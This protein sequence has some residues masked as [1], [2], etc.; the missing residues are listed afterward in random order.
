MKIYE[1][2]LI[3]AEILSIIFAGIW[4]IYKLNSMNIDDLLVN[5]TTYLL[6]IYVAVG[7]LINQFQKSADIKK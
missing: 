3:F 6:M 7:N 5:N 4:I 1:S 2:S